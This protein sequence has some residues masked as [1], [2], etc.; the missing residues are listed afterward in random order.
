MRLDSDGDVLLTG[1]ALRALAAGSDGVDLLVSPAGVA[2]ARL[3]P[4]VRDVLVFD[5]PWSG[6][7]P[8]PVDAVALGGLV[9][10]L[11]DRR[12]A[13]AVIFTSYHQS[14]LPMALLA[15]MAGVPRVSAMSEDYPGSLL[16]L[17]ERRLPQ[18]DDDG[19]PGGGHEVLAALRLAERAG[20]PRPQHDDG[21]LRVHV[22]S[23]DPDLRLPGPYVV[24][25]PVA[26]VPSRSIDPRHA[27]EI[28]HALSRE[29]WRVVLTGT[30]DQRAETRAI[31][32][33]GVRDLVGRTTFGQ[34]ARVLADAA[35]VVVGNTGP[36]HLAAA[37]GTP[38]VSLFSPVVP[39]ERWGPWGVPALVLGDQQAACRG[40]RARE[41]PLPGHPCLG[42]VTAGEVVGAVRQLAG[43]PGGS[44]STQATG[45]PARVAGGVR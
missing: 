12:Y 21:R 13:D 4:G 1:P 6:H 36:A 3:L 38:V 27:A 18:G 30:A 34:L 20:F 26:S 19:G 32:G 39:V 31:S 14:P 37:V 35:C 41:C 23:A 33:P 11:A 5:A 42:T 2:A 7:T 45:L 44:G 22:P 24:L 9:Q 28:A 29:G 17:R 43:T 8:P 15:R 10:T 16:D 40:T 25:H